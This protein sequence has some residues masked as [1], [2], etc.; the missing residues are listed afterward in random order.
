MP[1]LDII[2]T[3][4]WHGVVH[5]AMTDNLSVDKHIIG[6]VDGAPREGDAAV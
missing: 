1:V 6:N 3:S 5:A 2:N 4:L